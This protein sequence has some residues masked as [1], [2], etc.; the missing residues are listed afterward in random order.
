MLE[1]NSL[2]SAVPDQGQSASSAQ[3][4]EETK[5]KANVQPDEEAQLK[6]K[7]VEPHALFQA[8]LEAQVAAEAQQIKEA[9]EAKASVTEGA[10]ALVKDWELA[11]NSAVQS[12]KVWDEYSYGQKAAYTEAQK[13]L[14]EARSMFCQAVAIKESIDGATGP[15]VTL[16]QIMKVRASVAQSLRACLRSWRG[17]C[18]PTR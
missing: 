16:E 1:V 12:G 5:P 3:P 14:M 9:M 8:R 4:A 15:Q 17:R 11:M 10:K 2:G 18:S 13:G 6:A 7:V